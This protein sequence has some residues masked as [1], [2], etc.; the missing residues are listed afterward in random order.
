MEC[1]IQL[2]KRP[3]EALCSEIVDEWYTANSLFVQNLNLYTWWFFFLCL[4][5]D[6]LSSTISCILRLLCKRLRQRSSL[7]FLIYFIYVLITNHESLFSFRCVVFNPLN[8]GIR[9]F[10]RQ[11]YYV[12][13]FFSAPYD[14]LDNIILTVFTT[15]FRSLPSL[16]Q[17]KNGFIDEFIKTAVVVKLHACSHSS[18]AR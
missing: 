12:V 1:I 17:Y 7:F 3:E 8:G 14:C 13:F 5:L 9:L 18:V 16:Q 11:T 10:S 2:T 6:K 15:A 4:Q